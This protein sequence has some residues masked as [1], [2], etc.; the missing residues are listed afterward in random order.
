MSERIGDLSAADRNKCPIFDVL[1]DWL[2]P[3]AA[4]LEIGAG[5]GTHAHYAQ[6]RMPDAY[7][8]ASEAPGH[9]RRLTAALVDAESTRLPTPLAL[10]VRG[11]WP[12][13]RFDAIFGANIAHIMNEH[14]VADLFAGAATHLV[15]RGLLCL[16]GP[17][18][19]SDQPEGEGNR[20]FDRALR[21]RGQ[22]MGIRHRDCLDALARDHGLAPVGRV[23]MPSD[24]RLLFW[25]YAYTKD[26]L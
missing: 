15:E 11:R 21:E 18:F 22:G 10:D 20:V 5:D 8:Q 3:D 13:R 7:W 1:V 26:S 6:K 9:V 12:D 4:V 16:Y 23:F 17:F 25:R 2:A 19:E 14:A 24:N